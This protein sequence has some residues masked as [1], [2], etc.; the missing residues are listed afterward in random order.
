MKLTSLFLNSN[1]VVNFDRLADNKI[2]ILLVQIYMK[3]LPPTNI[4]HLKQFY[5]ILADKLSNEVLILKRYVDE[6]KLK[7]T[8]LIRASERIL[9]LLLS[10]IYPLCT[11]RNSFLVSR[12]FKCLKNS[13]FRSWHCLRI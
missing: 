13:E 10:A 11:I 5:P 4:L 1:P 2:Y 12:N 3:I 7:N 6:E 9:N 8:H